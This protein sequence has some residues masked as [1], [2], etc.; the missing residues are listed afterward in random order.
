MRRLDLERIEIEGRP[1]PA[2]PASV[3]SLERQLGIKLPHGYADY[4]TTLG[5][6]LLCGYVRVYLPDRV[7]SE[8]KPWRR[9]IKQHWFWNQ[10]QAILQQDAALKSVV[11]ADTM[12]GDELI[13]NP[14]TGRQYVLPRHLEEAF[15]VGTD[16]LAA[17]DWF[18]SSGVLL[19]KTKDCRFEPATSERQKTEVIERAPATRK[20]THREKQ[21]REGRRLLIMSASHSASGTVAT[22]AYFLTPQHRRDGWDGTSKFTFDMEAIISSAQAAATRGAKQPPVVT[23]IRVART[24]VGKDIAAYYYVTVEFT[25]NKGASSQVLLDLDGNVVEPEVKTFRNHDKYKEYEDS[26]RAA[27]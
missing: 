3:T 7:A 22:S 11:L 23:S 2:T 14:A 20:S 15:E 24:F 6:G 12:E 21:H 13:Y 25:T 26:L 5:D 4:V 18:C 19:P 9:R 8:L 16:F 1:M 27:Y 17:M 10:T